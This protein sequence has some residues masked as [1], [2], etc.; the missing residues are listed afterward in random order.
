[1]LSFLDRCLSRLY[2]IA[3]RDLWAY[4]K[5]VV[6]QEASGIAEFSERITTL[7]SSYVMGSN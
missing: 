5:L 2:K 7:S 1:M 4:Q 3:S 6:F